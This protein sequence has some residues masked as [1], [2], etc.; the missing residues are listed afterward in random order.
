MSPLLA[1][2]STNKL[3]F[4]SPHQFPCFNHIWGRVTSRLYVLFLL[5]D[6]SLVALSSCNQA[7]FPP[8][9]GLQVSKPDVISQ[10]EQGTEP[11]TVEPGI[12]GGAF[13]GE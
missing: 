6:A 5:S 7:P 12:P 8:R 1:S 13:G 3:I 9:A 4:L 11:W 2:R 10:L